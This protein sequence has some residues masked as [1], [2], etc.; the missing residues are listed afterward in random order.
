MTKKSFLGI[1][2]G[3]NWRQQ[4]AM[5]LSK[6]D[7]YAKIALR[8]RIDIDNPEL[9]HTV[10][11]Q[12]FDHTARLREWWRRY[13]HWLDRWYAAQGPPRLSKHNEWITSLRAAGW[14]EKSIADMQSGG[15]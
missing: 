14:T 13:N 15:E 6:N 9:V 10:N 5:E 2:V 7:K 11:M 8:S 4:P 3:I 12:T 1:L